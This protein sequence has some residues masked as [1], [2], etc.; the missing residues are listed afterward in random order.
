MRQEKISTNHPGD[1]WL[2]YYFREEGMWRG[3]EH[4]VFGPHTKAGDRS[5]N[6]YA[7]NGV[8]ILTEE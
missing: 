4:R 8:W 7:L 2:I 6:Y 5:A 3:A 1:N